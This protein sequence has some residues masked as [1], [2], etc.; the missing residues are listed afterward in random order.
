MPLNTA[1]ILAAAEIRASL[2]AKR[3]WYAYVSVGCTFAM[4]LGRKVRRD[5]EEV[6][7]LAELRKRRKIKGASAS[8]HP[9]E[10]DT[11]KG[12]S[13]L[14]VWC[15]WRLADSAGP[16]ASSDND[17]ETCEQA[18]AQLVGK[19]VRHVEITDGWDVRLEFSKSLVLTLFPDH[20]GPE[21]S[22]DTNWE[23]WRPDRAYFVEADLTCRVTDPQERALRPQPGTQRWQLAEPH[24]EARG[25]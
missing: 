8:P 22:M 17:R 6:A 12:E 25:A 21:A 13:H 9:R 15:A 2:E 5:P 19:T 10:Y 14:L 20:V 1:D 24:T 18:V 23:L 3:C 11:H 16:V 7:A 4:D